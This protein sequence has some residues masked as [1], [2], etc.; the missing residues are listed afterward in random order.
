MVD[1]DQAKMGVDRKDT[2]QTSYQ[3]GL[4]GKYLESKLFIIICN[5]IRNKLKL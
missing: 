4:V 1:S 3:K 2:F 5:R